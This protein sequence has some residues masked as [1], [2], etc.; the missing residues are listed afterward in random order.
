[1]YRL[2]ISI[3]LLGLFVGCTENNSRS[4]TDKVELEKDKSGELNVSNESFGTLMNNCDY[5][6][7][8]RWEE[9][10]SKVESEINPGEKLKI[11][12]N[13]IDLITLNEKPVKLK[14]HGLN[15]DHIE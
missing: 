10:N 5:K 12:G 14:L 4:G 8:V 13:P 3:L 2:I 15:V 6:V 11:E 7:N 1:M 9:G